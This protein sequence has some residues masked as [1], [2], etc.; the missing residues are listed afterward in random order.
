MGDEREMAFYFRLVVL[1][2]AAVF[3]LKSPHQ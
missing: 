3:I 2:S 1:K